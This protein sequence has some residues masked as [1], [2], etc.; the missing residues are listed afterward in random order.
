MRSRF[1]LVALA[2]AAALPSVA[3][4]VDFS[5]NGFSTAAY[6]TSDTDDALVGYAG[7]PE[8]IDSEGSYKFDSKLGAQVTA[9]FNEMVSATVQGVAYTDLTGDF[10]PRLD[11]AYLKLQPLQ[12]LSFRAGYLRAPTYMYSDSIF[13]GYSNVW[14]RA[15]LEVYGL[16]PVYQMRGADVTWSTQVAGFSVSVNPYYGDTEVETATGTL[17]VPHWG[18]LVTTVQRGSFQARIGYSKYDFGNATASLAPALNALRAIPASA[19]DACASEAD[20]LDLEATDVENYSVG[21][22]YDDGANFLATEYAAKDTGGSYIVPSRTGAYVT[23]GRR[24]GGLMPYATYA[25]SDR[26]SVV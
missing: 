15:P 13:I 19:C 25:I 21:V 22:Q 26:K 23:Y 10:E 11:W 5:Y 12:N 7:Q 6:T 17:D 2:V 24:F 20:K 18:G 1:S 9:K 3:S 14:V 8:G 4:A 16:G